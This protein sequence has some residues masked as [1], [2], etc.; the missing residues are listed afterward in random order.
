M[1]CDIYPRVWIRMWTMWVTLRI[2]YFQRLY[3][4]ITLLI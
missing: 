3:M 2:Q 1:R 4:W